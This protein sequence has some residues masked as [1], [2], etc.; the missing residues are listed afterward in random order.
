MT[1]WITVLSRQFA[2]R[3]VQEA[4]MQERRFIPV[5][6]QGLPPVIQYEWDDEIIHTDSHPFCGDMMCPCRADFE[7]IMEYVY[8]PV[9][10][11]LLT[12]EEGKRLYY[13]KQV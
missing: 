7:L 1:D 5:L 4:E 11:G 6:F 13:G 12:A 2:K 10:D 3:L 8:Q 9:Q